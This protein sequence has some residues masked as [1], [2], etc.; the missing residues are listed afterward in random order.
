MGKD[1][2]PKKHAIPYVASLN[3]RLKTGIEKIHEL[4]KLNKKYE[5]QSAVERSERIEQVWKEFQT[6]LQ[7]FILQ[8]VSDPVIT[9]DLLQEVFLKIHQ[10]I[11]GLQDDTKLE[12][13]VYQIT[14][15]TIIDHY[16]TT[17]SHA[18]IDTPP[19][20]EEE[21]INA[22]AAAQLAPGLRGLVEE[23]PEH[24]RRAIEL[25]EFEGLTQREMGER[26]GLSV[27]GAKSRVQRA[28]D[29]L[30][31]MLLECCHFT[32]DNR[33]DIVDYQPKC[34]HCATDHSPERSEE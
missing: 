1:R 2:T 30:K 10:S 15:N 14:R 16:R 32:F 4:F 8:R 24:Y 28:R 9:E 11:D 3:Q 26:L 34:Q 18:E 7:A 19:I 20:Y 29:L 27:S 21:Y 31:E 33:G 6:Q 12:S 22:D 23:L 13:W 5:D 25:T 17:K